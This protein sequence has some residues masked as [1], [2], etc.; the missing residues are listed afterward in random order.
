MKLCIKLFLFL[1]L[2][3]ISLKNNAQNARQY[4]KT[5]L[6][7]SEAGNYKD[8]V[9]QFTRSLEIDPEYLSSYL[10]RAR[11]YEAMNE[12]Q[13]AA[14]DLQR[15]LSFEQKKEALYYE[16]ARLN[17]LLSNF[18]N[19]LELINRSMELKSNYE[20]AFR[21]QCLVMLATGDYS[22]AL[23]SI[24][25]ALA[26]KDSPENN[27]YHGQVSEN[28]KNYDQAESDYSK[29]I[30]KNNK[31]TEA[32]LAL[33]SLRIGMNKPEAALEN[34]NAV[35][36]YAPDNQ[37]AYI[38]RSRIYAQLTEYPKAIDDISKILHG[39]PEEKEMYLLRGTYYQEFMQ[40]QNAISDFTH[41][42]LIDNAFV[43]ACYKRALSYEQ[44]GDLKSAIKDYETLTRLS[45]TDTKAALLLVDVR[46]RLFELNRE[47]QPPLLTLLEPKVSA[48]SGIQVAQNKNTVILRG[49]IKE[50]SELN[51]VTVNGKPA[52]FVHTGD[53]YDFAAETDVSLMEHITITA[54]DV[55][56][57][58]RTYV[59]NL[60]RT[61]IN[62]PV[63]T[64]M[65]PYASDNGEIYLDTD[66]STLYI[67]G[68]VHDESTIR[69]IVIDSV[70]AS[71]NL[72]EL[73]PRF[74][75]TINVGNKNKF[76][77]R[78]TD[79]FGNDTTQTYVLNRNGVSLLKSNPVGRTWVIFIE[80]SNYQ[81]FPSLEG[82]AKDVELMR[83]ALERYDIQKII[84][85]QDMTKMEM[86]RFFSIEL[87][88]LLRSNQ[89]DALLLWY[90]GHGR[91]M[92]E[93]G[94]WIPVDAR[95]DDEFT[96]YNLNALRASLQSYTGYITHKLVITDACES[97]PTFYQAM[98]DVPK[99]RNC[100]DRDAVKSKSSQVFSS[101][102]YEMAA[103]NSQFTKTFASTLIDNPDACLPIETI[104]DKVTQAVSKNNQQKPLFGKITG[105]EDE[106]GTFFF[107]SKQ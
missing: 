95:R 20:P 48:D 13:K 47:T 12:L 44:A 82:P 81:S 77:V 73:N 58:S 105:L 69:S 56:A 17:Y 6:T 42:L 29:A 79:S 11:A 102:G 68:I 88:D 80:N 53:E 90:T 18:D 57:N 106:D 5:G 70:S 3:S 49:K 94:Y 75:A 9:D 83:S 89:V 78:T 93:T 74:S 1:L 101:A 103:D 54:M 62:P 67:E 46:K 39:N 55:Y 10:E 107:I 92:N 2:L 30:S 66:N 14:D 23:I 97:G 91:Y 65:A 7:F 40:Y 84:Y 25:K 50:E 19:A 63:A 8:A 34:C 72:N 15:A 26:L 52:T 45:N 35:I 33:A 21:L 16:A 36:A 51:N 43:D 87:R 41:A 104:V 71:F 76:T 99:E 31:Y 86:E 38:V 4:F 100:S 85:K 28:M 24:N 32:Y 98:R 59:F 60:N 27:F 37:Q 22:G 61:E 64:I 96:Y